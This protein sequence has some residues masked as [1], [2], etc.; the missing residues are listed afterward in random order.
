MIHAT[1][2]LEGIVYAFLTS[3][4][5][6]SSFIFIK[7]SMMDVSA[8]TY[9]AVRSLVSL[10]VLSPFLLRRYVVGLFD[11]T[12]FMHGLTIGVSYA[13]GL[14]L[15][16]DGTKYISPSTSAFITGL[17]TLHVHLYY[18]TVKKSY[19]LFDALSLSLA[20]S[21]LYMLT[22]PTGEL[23]TG[24]LMVFLGSIAWGAQ[25]ILVSRY[26]RGSMLETLGGMFLA[27]SLLFPLVPVMERTELS[28]EAL[29]YLSYLAIFCSLVASFFQ[30]LAQR[31]ISAKSAATIYLLEPVFALL[32][33][34]VAGMEGLNPYKLIGGGLISIATYVV[35]LQE[36][37]SRSVSN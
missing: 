21:G 29:V 34:L 25:I 19:N 9:T 5:W 37:K 14:F 33:S 28:S 15:Q 4:I 7:L 6:G 22:G 11:K 35:I 18:A 20:V 36:S 10:A 31:Y 12:S 17:N 8:I 1:R 27:G 30:V 13:L 26:S 32:F 23:N 16:A 2:K 3:L 24:A